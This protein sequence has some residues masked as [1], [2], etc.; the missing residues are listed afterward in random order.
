MTAFLLKEFFASV[1]SRIAFLWEEGD[2]VWAALQRIEEF[3]ENK[4]SFSIETEI[5]PQVYLKN[6]DRISI[7]PGTIL[8]PGVYLEGPC[9]L[10][11]NCLVRHGAYVRSY[12]I[13][14]DRCAIGHG[15]EIKRS[16]LMNGATAAH[17]NY[18]GDSILGEHVNLGA[19]VKCANLR[20]DRKEVSVYSEGVKIPT[21][22]MKFGCVLGDGVQIGCNS[23]VNPGTLIGPGSFVHPLLHVQG[24]IGA[25]CQIKSQGSF[26]D[27]IPISAA[28]IEQLRSHV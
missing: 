2:P 19:G 12:T 20:L 17:F 24:A 8:E 22:L 4:T 21:G 7:G 16:I 13:A 1:D 3:F 15:S 11:A 28:L 23:V 5:G 18:V 14:G 26:P 9:V 6:P 25:R 10:G 27:V